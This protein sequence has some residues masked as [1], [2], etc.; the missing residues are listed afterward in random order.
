MMVGR[1]GSEFTHSAEPRRGV[2]TVEERLDCTP[3]VEDDVEVVGHMKE[4]R[5][6]RKKADNPQEKWANRLV[7]IP[8]FPG[9]GKSAF[10]AR[11]PT[12]NAWREF[13]GADP[14]VA[15]LTWNNAMSLEPVSLGLRMPHGA[16]RGMGIEDVEWAQWIKDVGGTVPNAIISADDASGHPPAPFRQSARTSTCRRAHQVRDM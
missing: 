3:R 5:C 10:L 4:R 2:H 16:V 8:G 12:S 6:R 9:S 13:V 14:I 1:A 7:A 11:F 15:T